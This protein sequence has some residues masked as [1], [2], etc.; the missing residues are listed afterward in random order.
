MIAPARISGGDEYKIGDE[1]EV[2]MPGGMVTGRVVT[3]LPNYA[4]SAETRYSIHGKGFVTI[5]SARVM[6]KVARPNSRIED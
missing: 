4:W 6:R 3:V 1:V 5:S 2:D